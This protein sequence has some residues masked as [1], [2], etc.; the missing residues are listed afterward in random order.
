MIAASLL[1]SMSGFFV[2]SP[3]IA[4]GIDPQYRGP[5]LACYRALF[6]TALMLPFVRWKSI[7]WRAGLVPMVVA[8]AAMNFLFISALTRTTAAAAIFLQYTSTVWAFL[9]GRLFL[10][11][12]IRRGHLAAL[13]GTLLG[14][15]WIVG[16]DW[17]GANVAG[18]LL[19]MGSGF[20][21]A[22]VVVALRFLRDED[23]AWLVALN[24]LASGLVLLPWVA[25]LP[26]SLTIVQWTVIAFLGMFQM[27]TPYL[28]FARGVKTIPSQDAALLSL[29]EPILNPLWVWLAWGERIPL[30]TCLGGLF[31]LGGLAVRYLLFREESAEAA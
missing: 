21:Y 2:K 28:L 14:I 20:C 1:W 3:P 27:A 29:L 5:V 12:P 19:A 30:T 18:N 6:A 15:G 23:S 7:R 24:H 13:A 11:E 17:G 26:V 25:M 4:Q 9:F 10:S 8:F 22:I 16:G 31:I